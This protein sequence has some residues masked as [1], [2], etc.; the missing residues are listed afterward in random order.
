MPYCPQCR[1][2]FREGFEI[3]PV[4]E[5]PLAAEIPPD[6]SALTPEELEKALAGKTL[7]TL[8]RGHFDAIK[9]IHILLLYNRIPNFIQPDNPMDMGGSHHLQIYNL[10]VAEDRAQEA[11]AIIEKYWLASHPETYLSLKRPAAEATAP[12]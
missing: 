12:R 1:S 11:Y 2:E 3:C 5:I 10:F 7:V 6:V 4:C 9:E 8:R